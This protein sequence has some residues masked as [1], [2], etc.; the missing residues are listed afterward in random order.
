MTNETVADPFGGADREIR[1]AGSKVSG[2][3]RWD[4]EERAA[5]V[6][7][8]R[9]R[10]SGLSWSEVAA[11]VA[12]TDSAR[13]I[14]D[15]RCPPDLFTS[16]DVI[17]QA[18]RDIIAWNDGDYRFLT[19][20]DHDYPVQLREVHQFPPV[21]FARGTL[22]ADDVGVC[23]VGARTASSTGLSNAAQIARLLV[24]RDLTVISGLAAGLDT[25]A[26]VS[27]LDH[28]GRT[29]AVI[30][31]G[32][33]RHYPAANRDLQNRIATNGLVLSQ[34]WP[35]APPT[36]SS[37]PMRN[38]TM[39][40]YGRATV[41]VEAGEKSGARIQARTAVAH[42]R[43]VI[44]MDSVA[45]GTQWGRA[46]HGQ[47]GVLVASTPADVV[48]HVDSIIRHDQEFARLLASARG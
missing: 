21:I 13:M 47:P 17:V 38:A 2:M 19:F 15:Q 41:I 42:G 11:E 44:L 31:T 1:P 18:R 20:A 40:A 9:V 29:V 28:G 33:E 25:A 30:G 45:L 4:D 23:V 39:S 16:D 27:A 46:L 10:P 3:A 5:L 34:F 8:L 6:A 43:P 36:K 35:D 32:I 22:R 7:L 14:W 26:H 37:F 48:G 24:E 12:G